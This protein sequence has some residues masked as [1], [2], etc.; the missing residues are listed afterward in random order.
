LQAGWGYDRVTQ[1]S[2]TTTPT[3]LGGKEDAAPDYVFNTYW[4]SFWKNIPNSHNYNLMFKNLINLEKNYLPH[5]N[6]YVEYDFRNLQA[7]EL[8]EDSF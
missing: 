3:M 8:L 5:V 4:H 1:H 2:P 6:E 7:L